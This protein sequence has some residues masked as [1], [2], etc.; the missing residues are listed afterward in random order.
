MDDTRRVAFEFLAL[1]EPRAVRVY[2]A[3]AEIFVLGGSGGMVSGRWELADGAVLHRR[4]GRGVESS[5]R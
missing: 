1:W 5:N 3:E 2:G 4:A